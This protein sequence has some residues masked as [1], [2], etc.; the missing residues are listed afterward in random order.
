[1]QRVNEFSFYEL[2]G[3]VHPLT[4][5]SEPVKFSAIWLNLWNAR[6]AICTILALRPLSV[7]V[8]A[9]SDLQAAITA[10]VPDKWEDLS[11][12]F[13][14]DPASEEP[15]PIWRLSSIERAARKFETILAAECSVLDTY[16]VSQKGAY[17]TADLI[18]HAHQQIP[19]SVRNKLPEQ[20]MSDIDQAGK[21][22]AFDLPTAAAFH[23]LRG[24]ES[25]LFEYYD[26]IVPGSKKA[27]PKMR[28]WGVYI[29]LLKRH[30]AEDKIISLLD[31]IK[32]AYRNPVFHPDESYS[33]EQALVLFGV[34]VS[35][36]V[37]MSQEIERLDSKGGLLPLSVDS[38]GATQTGATQ[39]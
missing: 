17:S 8:N 33:D 28:S 26:R 6:D 18:D 24:T 15:I 36:I 3:H 1:M 2:A 16:F 5:L 9:A 27:A 10:V 30:D 21:C 7:C 31:H 25:V 4:S 14:Q 13:P 20:T 35:A 29:N 12:I 38:A 34:C 37:M 11:S 23:L 22:I 32:N 19:L 39:E